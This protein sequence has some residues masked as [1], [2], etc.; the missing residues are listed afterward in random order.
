MARPVVGMQEVRVPICFLI[1]CLRV[2]GSLV[3][4]QR[5]VWRGR[6]PPVTYVP[7]NSGAERSAKTIDYVAASPACVG[8]VSRALVFQHGHSDHTGMAVVF[9]GLFSDISLAIRRPR[10][11]TA[12][13]CKSSLLQWRTQCRLALLD[14]TRPFIKD[15]SDAVSYIQGSLATASARWL[16]AKQS[17]PSLSLSS[18]ARREI[19]KIDVEAS[20][21]ATGRPGV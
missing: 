11:R 19:F 20:I 7:W 5:E 12:R 21:H 9:S 14:T 6:L 8:H 15:S 4:T 1:G 17:A 18:C 13:P 3:S 10:I 16:P 2:Q